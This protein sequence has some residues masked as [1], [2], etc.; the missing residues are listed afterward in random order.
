MVYD[1]ESLEAMACVAG[2]Q[3]EALKAARLFG[4]A[5]PLSEPLSGSLSEPVQHTPEEP[6]R[7]ED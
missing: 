7:R 5:E 6:S 1:L 2:A 4:V 3:E